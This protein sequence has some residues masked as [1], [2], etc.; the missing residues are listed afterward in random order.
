MSGVERWRRAGALCE[1]RTVR[2]TLFEFAGGEPAF[3]A[4][5]TAH[6]RLCLAEPV[7]SHPFSSPDQHPLHVQRLGQYWAEVMGGP[8]RFT[9]TS[10]G[11]QSSVLRIHSGSGD[12]TDLNRRFYECFVQAL[13]DAGLPEDPEFRTAMRDYMRWAVEELSAYP[14]DATPV[15][16]RAPMPHWT[17]SG[18]VS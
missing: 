7:L 14:D 16:E 18:L 11:G 15:P 12:L 3:L 17:W 13:D 4:L 9:E 5:A 10:D 6:H 1:C 2:P 8:P